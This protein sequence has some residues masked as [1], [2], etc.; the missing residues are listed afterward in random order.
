TTLPPCT[1]CGQYIPIKRCTL[2]GQ[3]LS[4]SS[5]RPCLLP[6][7]ESCPKC[8]QTIPQER[9]GRCFQSW[10]TKPYEALENVPSHTLPEIVTHSPL[11]TS[12][13]SGLSITDDECIQSGAI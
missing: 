12:V 5:S 4:L 2:C 1:N 13:M 3:A 7:I 9:C 10:M 6:D 8:S 11:I